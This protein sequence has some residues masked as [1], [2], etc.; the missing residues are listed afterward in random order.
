[1][2]GS[3]RLVILTHG[4]WTWSHPSLSFGTNFYSRFVNL[5]NG[6][7]LFATEEPRVEDL[8]PIEDAKWFENVRSSMFSFPFCAR[9]HALVLIN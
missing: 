3:T 2:I 1:M 8:L 6:D 4:R 9:L 7:A 5:C